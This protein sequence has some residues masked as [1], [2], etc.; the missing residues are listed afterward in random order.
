MVLVV[1]KKQ[2]LQLQTLLDAKVSANMEGKQVGEP[3]LYTCISSHDYEGRL[4]RR[5]LAAKADPLLPSKDERGRDIEL[6][7][8]GAALRGLTHIVGLLLDAKT[9]IDVRDR[10]EN[11]TP[12]QCAALK[13]W[14][15][16]AAF[17]LDRNAN[18]NIC[19]KWDPSTIALAAKGGNIDVVK[20]LLDRKANPNFSRSFK[21]IDSAISR[22]EVP[23]IKLLVSAKALVSYSQFNKICAH[24]DMELFDFVIENGA[25]KGGDINKPSRE[26]EESVLVTA[27]A[28]GQTEIVRKLLDMK[29]DANRTSMLRGIQT[30]HHPMIVA[31]EQGAVDIVEMFLER[32]IADVNRVYEGGINM[33]RVEDRPLPIALYYGHIDLVKCLL[34]HKADPKLDTDLFEMAV[35]HCYWEACW[36]LTEHGCS[37]VDLGPEQTTDEQRDHH[38]NSDLADDEQDDNEIDEPETTD[39]QRDHHNNSDPSDDEQDDNEIDEPESN[40]PFTVGARMRH[41]GSCIVNLERFCRESPHFT[42]LHWACQQRNESEVTRL[43]REGYDPLLQTQ[44]ANGLTPW[45]IAVSPNSVPYL[46]YVPPPGGLEKDKCTATA[47]PPVK[48]ARD[49]D[50]WACKLRQF[51]N[52]ENKFWKNEFLYYS[53]Q[54]GPE[55]DSREDQNGEKEQLTP[56]ERYGKAC[57]MR[58]MW[59]NA[60]LRS[61]NEVAAPTKQVSEIEKRMKLGTSR[62]EGYG[63]H[64]DRQLNLIPCRC[65]IPPRDYANDGVAK[66]M[67]IAVQ[68]WSRTSH[69]LWPESFRRVVKIGFLARSRSHGNQ[70]NVLATITTDLWCHVLGFLGRDAFGELK[71]DGE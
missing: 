71:N 3:L 46:F 18:M 57:T 8:H 31:C 67:S 65:T 4:V 32:G 21:A 22:K 52:L 28:A 39:E 59:N 64:R 33:T 16:T 19:D 24:G 13:G 70:D 68:P 26:S 10:E 47:P 50:D 6:P 30:L 51:R 37:P 7:I 9:P 63:I 69:S 44:T 29:A 56:E 58:A 36:L 14:P 43:L 5:L 49:H 1:A 20:L 11:M 41:C 48:E 38:N 27:T 66:L 15:D 25:L 60:V 42:Q 53:G 2:E 55:D 45:Q 12:L 23:I 54:L 61:R 40:D 34:D 62:G 35:S 17:L